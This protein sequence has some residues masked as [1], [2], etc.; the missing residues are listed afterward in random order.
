MGNNFFRK[1]FN[2][3]EAQT[4][5]RCCVRKSMESTQLLKHFR[6]GVTTSSEE[7]LSK[8]P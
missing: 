8:E 4:R 6:N 1:D 7:L 3:D 5:L 2:S